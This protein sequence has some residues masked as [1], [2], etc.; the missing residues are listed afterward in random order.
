MSGRDLRHPTHCLWC[1]TPLVQASTGRP[2]LYHAKACK[3]ASYRCRLREREAAALEHLLRRYE[4]AL[5]LLPSLAMEERFDLLAAVVWPQ[6]PRL[7][8]AA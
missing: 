7:L 1:G 8:E 4:A 3:Q 6:D 5:P 2:P